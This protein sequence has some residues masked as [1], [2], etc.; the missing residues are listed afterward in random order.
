MDP[1]FS[2]Y[3]NCQ[4]ARLLKGRVSGERSSESESESEGFSKYN[5]EL[6]SGVGF[7][8]I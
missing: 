7:E 4:I 8:W 6:S 2:V 5:L 3:S 1:G